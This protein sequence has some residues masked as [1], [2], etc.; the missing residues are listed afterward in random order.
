MLGSA[1]VIAFTLVAAAIVSYAQYIF[2][3]F[4]HQ[5]KFNIDGIISLAGNSSVVM[6][7]AVY[8]FGLVFYLFALNSGDLSLVYPAFS[9]SFIFVML[10]SHF[11][12][13]E[14]MGYYRLAVMLLIILGIALVSIF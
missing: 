8:V 7:I 2:K 14:R 13:K 11:K 10:I 4:V 3:R 5:F 1:Y 6:G 9:S 12:L